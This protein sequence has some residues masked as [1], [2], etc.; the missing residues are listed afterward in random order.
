MSHWRRRTAPCVVVIVKLL[1]SASLFGSDAPTERDIQDLIEHISAIPPSSYDIEVISEFWLTKESEEQLMKSVENIYSQTDAAALEQSADVRQRN[2]EREVQ[3]LLREQERPRRI[4]KR[5]RYSET[6]GYREDYV[7]ERLDTGS[8]LDTGPVETDE[9]TKTAVNVGPNGSEETESFVLQHQSKIAS[10]RANRGARI[11]NRHVWT[12]GTIGWRSLHILNDQLKPGTPDEELLARL[13][14]EGEHPVLQLRIERD[15]E[16]PDGSIGRQYLLK[17]R[18]GS[19][20]V[21]LTYKV[22]EDSFRPVWSVVVKERNVAVMEVLR[23]EDGI[24]QEWIDRGPGTPDGGIRYTL[25]SKTLNEELDPVLFTFGPPEGFDYVDYT[26]GP[27]R[28]V[29]ADGRVEVAEQSGGPS[30]SGVPARN[31]W[32]LIVGNGIMLAAVLFAWWSRRRSLRE[33]SAPR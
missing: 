14:L 10:R 18:A 6:L 15:I 32:G 27:P 9:F 26:V 8:N 24:A 3:R 30:D 1:L 12:G 25:I 17:V 20:T 13:L 4:R 31:W 23:A 33:D 22:P 5:C 11:V 29:Y 21:N 19:K 28:T 7:I 2:V 16:L